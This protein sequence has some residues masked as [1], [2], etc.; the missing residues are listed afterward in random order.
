MKL[1]VS[2]HWKKVFLLNINKLKTHLK[3]TFSMEEKNDSLKLKN[4]FKLNFR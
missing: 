2:K 4:H 1:M 3:S